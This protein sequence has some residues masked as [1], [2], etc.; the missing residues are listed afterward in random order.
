MLTISRTGKVAK[1]YEYPSTLKGDYFMMQEGR[2]AA[3]TAPM[4]N[5][6]KW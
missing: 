4:M 5:P 2:G 3:F 6:D 1:E